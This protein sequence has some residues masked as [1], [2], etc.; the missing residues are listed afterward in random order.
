MEITTKAYGN[1]DLVQVSGRIDSNTSP[2]L[3]D[4]LKALLDANRYRIVLDLAEVTFVSSSGI[5]VILET[6]KAC[7]KH[8][9]GNL[10]ITNVNDE[11]AY[12]LELAGLHRFFTYYD[13]ITAAVASFV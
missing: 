11:I 1:C 12:S 7:K 5:W 10:V 4:A 13:D 9:G 8:R 3:D 6:Q 2:K